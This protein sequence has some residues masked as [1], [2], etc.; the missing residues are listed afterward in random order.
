LQILQPGHLQSGHLQSGHLQ[1]LCDQATTVLVDGH[2]LLG[3]EDFRLVQMEI[4]LVVRDS[5]VRRAVEALR[6]S[7]VSGSATCQG[8]ELVE[9]WL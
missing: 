8:G 3:E 5:R 4:Q 7:L 9:W 6:R 2:D 1:S